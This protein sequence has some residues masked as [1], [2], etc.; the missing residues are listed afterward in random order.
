MVLHVVG[1]QPMFCLLLSEYW[2]HAQGFHPWKAL[3]AVSPLRRTLMWHENSFISISGKSSTE[4]GPTTRIKVSF[5]NKHKPDFGRFQVQLY[6]YIFEHTP[7]PLWHHSGC[8]HLLF[9][10]LTSPI[11]RAQKQKWSLFA[12]VPWFG[13]GTIPFPERTFKCVLHSGDSRLGLDLALVAQ[14]WKISTGLFRTKRAEFPSQK[15]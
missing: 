12:S 2:F 13:A 4:L 9:S 14:A 10:S 11:I 5:H 3:Q 15:L 6:Q 1:D 7:A 8:Q